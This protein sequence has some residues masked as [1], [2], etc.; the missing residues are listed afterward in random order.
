MLVQIL[1][2]INTLTLTLRNI[3]KE[4]VEFSLSGD[5]LSNLFFDEA[6]TRA[7]HL[8]NSAA[9]V[10]EIKSSRKGSPG[11]EPPIVLATLC[12]LCRPFRATFR[13]LI[14]ETNERWKETSEIGILEAKSLL[15]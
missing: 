6:E 13:L 7:F 15:C 12:R 3:M 10:F 9:E 4:K 2:L 5:C 1:C 8:M 11:T 14:T